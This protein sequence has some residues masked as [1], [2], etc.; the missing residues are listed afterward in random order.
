MTNKGQK[1]EEQESSHSGSSR[2]SILRTISKR[3]IRILL[4]WVFFFACAVAVVRLLPTVYLAEAVVLIDSQKI[5]EKFVAATVTTDLED[6]IASIRQQLLSGG[7]LKK[8]IDEFGLYREE[9]KTHFEEEILDLMRKDISI[10]LDSAMPGS[11]GGAGG[12]GKTKRPGA[13]RIGFQGHDP[14]LVMQVAN[15]LTDLYVEQNLKT[16]E[17]QASGTSEFLETQV[18]EAKKQLDDMEATVSTYKLK[19]NGEL[20]QQEHAISDTLTRLQTELEVNR[21]AT[22]RAYQTKLIQESSVSAMEA[23]LSAQTHSSEQALRQEGTGGYSVTV[24]PAAPRTKQSEAMEDQLA[25]LLGRYTESHPEIIRLRNAIAQAKHAEEQRQ[26]PNSEPASPSPDPAGKATVSKPPANPFPEPPEFARTREQIAVLKA[27]ISGADTELENRK[28]EQQRI[29][30]DLNLYQRRIERLPVREQEMA[31]ITRDY[32][33]SK[34]NYKSLLDKKMAADMSLDMEQRQQS[35]RFVVLDRAQLPEKPIQPNRPLLYA[36]GSGV[37]LLLALLVGFGTELRKN[38]L[39]GE[40]ELP[41]GTNILARLPIIDVQGGSRTKQSKGWFGRKKEFARVVPASVKLSAPALP[42]SEVG[43][44]ALPIDGPSTSQIRTLSLQ[45]AAGSPILPFESNQKRASEQYRI[46]RTKVSQHPKKPHLIVV[47]SP[48]SGDGKSVTAINTAG[49]VALKSE[50]RVL[51]LDADLRKSVIHTQLGLP[52]SP[53]LADV[54]AGD[55][56]LEQALVQTMEFPNLFVLSSGTPPTNPVELLDSSQWVALCARLREMFRYVIIDSPPVGAVADYELIEAACDG[57][58]LVARPDFTNRRLFQHSLD[59]VPKAK[60][61]GVLMNCV[62]DWSPARQAGGDYY[63]YSGTK[64]Y[65]GTRA[66]PAP[67]REL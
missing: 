13:F 21:D 6:R 12:T 7:E 30:R 50:G 46:L 14:Q 39:L 3:K 28:L 38:V 60:F 55:C 18:S 4:S 31:Q 20:P 59:F 8:V 11:T 56:T 35:E 58:I 27:Q 54:L 43:P 29:L 17:G 2:L 40:W 34:E 49:A 45:L 57:V 16:R 32:E 53:G 47:S 52:E 65:E 1:D 41:T 23:T 48:E 33:I 36:A 25:L 66:L 10:S 61:L 64:V 19:H 26:K 5:P 15:R 51:L 24:N 42:G 9:R 67:Q 63:Y 44:E 62:P 37:S 22:N